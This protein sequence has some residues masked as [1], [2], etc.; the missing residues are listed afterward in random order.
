MIQ[1]NCQALEVCAHLMNTH[2][3]FY[4]VIKTKYTTHH[5]ERLMASCRDRGRWKWIG[6]TNSEAYYES[7]TNEEARTSHIDG[8]D[9][10]PRIYFLRDS[11]INEFREW[12]NI[13]NLKITNIEAPKV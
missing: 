11:F 3:I 10:F 5:I 1:E 2:T 8:G 13:R 9:L 6:E 12:L 4:I 7:G